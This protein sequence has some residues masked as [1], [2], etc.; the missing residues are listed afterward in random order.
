MLWKCKIKYKGEANYTES[1]QYSEGP[2]TL[3]DPNIE[4]AIVERYTYKVKHIYQPFV[5]TLGENT[6]IFPNGIRA[7]PQTTQNDIIW[8]KWKPKEQKTSQVWEFESSSFKGEIYKV[9]K[10]EDRITCSCPGVWRSKDRT[11]K[12]IKEVQQMLASKTA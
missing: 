3:T 2:I 10:S 6:I 4:S 11:C 8:E 9:K 7:H 1:I 5:L 12:H